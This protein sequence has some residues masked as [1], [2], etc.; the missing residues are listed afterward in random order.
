MSLRASWERTKSHLRKARCELPE[1]PTRGH[2]GGTLEG[3]EEY[4]NHNEL[5]LALDELEGLA[6]ANQT[7]SQF[8]FNMRAAASEMSLTHHVE[9]YSR[10]LDCIQPLFDFELDKTAG[11]VRFGEDVIPGF[12][13]GVQRCP[14]CNSHRFYHDTFDAYYCAFCNLWLEGAFRD[15]EC[16]YCKSR[17][18]QPMKTKAN[19]PQPPI[20]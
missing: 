9:R 18:V 13:D 7:S 15:S 8:W 17:P 20:A 12:V 3:F 1:A 2:E 5:E 19:K 16:D 11:T 6:S 4:L 10:I 14:N